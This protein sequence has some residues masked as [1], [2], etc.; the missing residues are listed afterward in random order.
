MEQHPSKL[1]TAHSLSAQQ[2]EKK[3]LTHVDHIGGSA[4]SRYRQW[5]RDVHAAERA[6][7]V[8]FDLIGCEVQQHRKIARASLDGAAKEWKEAAACRQSS[9]IE[10]VRYMWQEFL[11]VHRGISPVFVTNNLLNWVFTHKFWEIY[12]LFR[13]KKVSLKNVLFGW[14]NPP[15]S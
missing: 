1:M 3:S 5:A 4:E 13:R 7:E 11:C 6:L 8:H 9:K 10:F 14:E 15:T 12:V 2:R